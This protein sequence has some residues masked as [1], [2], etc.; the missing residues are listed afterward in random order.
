MYS[1]GV[2][3]LFMH[4]PESFGLLIPGHPQLPPNNDSDLSNL[5]QALL[6]LDPKQR[7]SAAQCIVHVYFR[8]NFVDR[9]VQD[10]E[11]VEQ[12]RKLEAVRHLIQKTRQSNRNN[13]DRIEVRRDHILED[14]FRYF[15]TA[16][17]TDI[18]KHLKVIFVGEPGVDEGG[19]TSE[20]FYLFF[21]E[22]FKESNG[23]F[24]T[25]NNLNKSD[26]EYNLIYIDS[27]IKTT[28]N[29]VLPSSTAISSDMMKKLYLV[30][31]AIVKS[32]YEG[33]RIGN[34]LCPSIFKYFTN[35]I[36]NLRDLQMF[37]SQTAKSLEWIL[38][39]Q[40]VDEVE[41]HFESVNSPELGVVTDLNKS[42]FIRMT[43]D[44]ILI[45]KRKLQLD[46]LKKGFFDGLKALSDEAA[47]FM[48]LLSHTD[49]RVMLC[50]DSVVNSGHILSVLTFNGF[51]LKSNIPKWLKEIL[52]SLS[53]DQLRKFL[54]F[55]T[56][57]PSLSST[58]NNMT[59]NVRY[60]NRSANLPT[61]HTCF[62]HLDIPDYKDKDTLYNKLIYAIHNS[63]TF[64][65]V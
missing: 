52:L 23:I 24:E 33:K 34:T 31:I 45:K 26:N 58:F 60:Q 32:L 64:E 40:N 1:F 36:P 46:Q 3:L 27:D 39:T 56:G 29:V 2:L 62:F 55:V 38:A 16:T 4:F 20:L 6:Q 8:T 53:E 35:T 12:D 37:D 48:S 61:A 14:G 9:L 49:W 13:I 18:K 59:I 30:G 15:E 42:K 19:L 65:I 25:S 57:S 54:V 51:P 22:V 44:Y 5:I 47:P 10:G 21:E 28:N 17:L 63:N 41:L 43:I 11:V 50:G 7:P